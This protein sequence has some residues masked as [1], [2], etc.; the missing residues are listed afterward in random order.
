MPPFVPEPNP[1]TRKRRI[2]N[3]RVSNKL[4]KKA[5]GVSHNYPTFREGLTQ[6]LDRLANGETRQLLSP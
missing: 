1:S 5:F 4:I 6:E 2:T 3:K